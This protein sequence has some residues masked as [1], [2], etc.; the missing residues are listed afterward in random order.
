M[1][2]DAFDKENLTT[3]DQTNLPDDYQLIVAVANAP[4]LKSCKPE[5]WTGKEP[6]LWV[7][8]QNEEKQFSSLAHLA[9]DLHQS[10]ATWYGLVTNNP[11]TWLWLRGNMNEIVNA[12]VESAKNARQKG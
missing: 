12:Y 6:I 11:K 9:D 1:A 4:D 5:G 10:E 3:A 2:A 8:E 7:R